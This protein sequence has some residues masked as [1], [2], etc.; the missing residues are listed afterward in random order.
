MAT[1]NCLLLFILA[2]LTFNSKETLATEESVKEIASKNQGTG[3]VKLCPAG[4][5]CTLVSG[6]ET[7][8]CVTTC[9]DHHKPVCGSDG[10]LYINHCDLHR[11]ACTTG[12]K[13]SIDWD[14]T[15][16]ELEVAKNK[17]NERKIKTLK[18]R[19][20]THFSQELV[21]HITARR[22]IVMLFGRQDGN[23]N[24]RL[25]RAEVGRFLL[26]YAMYP[27]VR[28]ILAYCDADDWMNYE[29]MDMDD[30]IS[31]HEF[32][33]SYEP[34]KREQNLSAVPLPVL[35]PEVAE[36]N[37]T[38]EIRKRQNKAEKAQPAEKSKMQTKSENSKDQKTENETSKVEK[39]QDKSTVQ[40]TSLR[41]LALPTR[42]PEVKT[43]TTSEVNRVTE[44]TPATKKPEVPFSQRATETTKQNEPHLETERK[45][46][47]DLT[48][49]IIV[50]LK[51]EPLP[52]KESTRARPGVT[53]KK[54]L[55]V[56]TRNVFFAFAD[57]GINVIDPVTSS[58]VHRM[59]G[60]DVIQ[61]TATKVCGDQ[62]CSWGDAVA[63][64]SG[65][66][67]AADVTN[68][69]LI[70]VDVSSLE[71]VEAINVSGFPYDLQ[72]V[73]GRDELWVLNWAERVTGLIT[74]VHG[75]NGT[76]AVIKNAM[77]KLTHTV[78]DVPLRHAIHSFHI[79]DS[80]HLRDEE[81]FGYVTHIEEPGIHEVDLA[82]REISRFID[83]SSRGCH[84]TY[85]FT[86]STGSD[87]GF[88]QCF[89]NEKKTLQ[90][91]YPIHMK[92]GT[93]IN[94]LTVNTGLP[95][96]SPDGKY[97]V[98]LNEHVISALYVNEERTIQIGEPIKT[99]M[100]LSDA[101]FIA[102][103]DGYDVYVTAKD[104]SAVVLIHASPSG[105][106]T[107]KL[108]T[109]V[110]LSKKKD[111]VR[112]KRS[113]VTGCEYDARYLATPAT[114][115]DAVFIIDGQRQVVSGHA[116]KIRGAQAL[117]WVSGEE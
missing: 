23:N 101:T 33:R 8:S 16:R 93:V 115:E 28:A 90:A 25:D 12:R 20:L 96:I 104:M 62:A 52:P 81:R 31:V 71:V 87:Y 36:P 27:D 116:Q 40:P 91:Q 51:K 38:A 109:D 57:E 86:Y 45:S 4:Q 60:N 56:K 32:F 54:D 65:V 2:I 49:P 41:P 92:T 42:E 114:A 5:T 13:I 26:N 100:S 95:H 94:V 46:K 15:C 106:E 18:H 34:S 10:H 103:D 88:V 14:D 47:K 80:C 83:L 110:G 58:V 113:I 37:V 24:R 48:E 7:C 98:S 70:V 21:G 77:E 68:R 72:Y 30:V 117:V 22:Y 44:K 102:R 59:R 19:I 64:G 84:G 73:S 39:A 111:W 55:S 85:G 3:C 69:R 108:L 50:N 74:Q 75:D 6:R 107:Q 105:M 82:A 112:V 79:T 78:T 61:N 9:P 76:L 35:L 29:D 11:L 17:C 63:V 97:I 89:T 67:Y 53:H 66:I 43:T 99:S 1:R